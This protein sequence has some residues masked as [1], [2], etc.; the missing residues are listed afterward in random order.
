MRITGVRW[1]LF[2]YPIARRR[3]DAHNPSGRTRQNGVVVEVLTDEEAIGVAVGAPACRPHLA[4]LGE[5]LVGQD[6][7]RARGLWE[8]LSDRLFEGGVVGAAADALSALD[9]AVWDLKAK[10]HG[11]PLWRLLGAAEGRAR[12]YASGGDMPLSDEQLA[13]FYRHM[14][15]LGFTAGKLKIGLSVD[16]DIRRLGVVQEA[17]GGA[18]ARPALMVDASEYWAPKQAVRRVQELE[19]H[20]DLTWVEEPVS[21]FDHVGLRSVSRSIRSPVAAGE[22]LDRPAQFLPYLAHGCVDVVQVNWSMTGIT[23]ALRIAEL[24]DAHGLPVTVGDSAGK[25]MAHVAA[26]LPNHMIM[27]VHD[28]HVEEPVIDADSGVV[29]G[30]V[31][32]GE[33]PGIGLEVRREALAAHAVRTLTPGSGTGGRGRRAGAARL[34]VPASDEERRIGASGVPSP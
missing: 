14:A 2:E 13:A 18:R 4:E 1:Q 9:V 28:D 24:A 21:R 12:G 8:R 31:V 32:L 7:R 17:L 15:G 16:D 33:R 26:A 29:D 23:G 6:P 5:A 10:A 27:E 25:F 34:E 22:N 11:V 30:F 19:R 20:F 3:G